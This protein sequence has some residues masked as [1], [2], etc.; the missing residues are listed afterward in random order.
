MAD[1]S[2]QLDNAG[3]CK[4]VVSKSRGVGKTR[5]KRASAHPPLFI[6]REPTILPS[7]LLSL[8]LSL[9]LLFHGCGAT[10][11][12]T[13][14]IYR[15]DSSFFPP[16]AQPLR[17]FALHL[18]PSRLGLLAFAPPTGRVSGGLGRREG[19][20]IYSNCTRCRRIFLVEFLSLFRSVISMD[21][22]SPSIQRE[23]PFF[24][25]IKH[26]WNFSLT[27]LISLPS[28]FKSI[29]GCGLVRCV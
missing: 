12:S 26:K 16:P 14:V 24:S 10:V 13:R 8:S 28:R 25:A 20:A 9:L 11:F 5:K 2:E 19:A 1:I 15:P 18:R 17:T 29:V 3:Q 23:R 27:I 6:S 22:F 7:F 4:V 21:L